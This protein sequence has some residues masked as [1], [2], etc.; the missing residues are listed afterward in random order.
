MKADSL[1]DEEKAKLFTGSDNWHTFSVREKGLRPVSMADGPHG[2]RIETKTGLG[3]NESK[4]AVCWP[5]ASALGCTFDRELIRRIAEKLSEECRSENIDLLLGPG[6]NHKRSPLCGRNFEYY[7]EDPY[8]S[9]ELGTAFVTGLQENGTGS[10]VK[11]YACN[12]REKGRLVQ[13]SIIDQRTLHEIYLRQFD[14][15]IRQAHPAAVMA[16]YNRLNGIYCCENEQ[17]LSHARDEG[18]DGI[19]IS[20][21]GAVSEPVESLKAGLNLQMPGGDHGTSKRILKALSRGKLDQAEIDENAER[22]CEFAARFEDH[23]ASA[24]DISGHLEGCLDAALESCVLLKNNGILPM[25]NQTVAVIG[26]LA[27]RPR[28]QGTGSSKVNSIVSDNLYDELIKAGYEAEYAQGYHLDDHL[29]HPKLIADAVSLAKKKELVIVAA[30]LN[31]GD[32]AEGHDRTTM[33]LPLVQN[34]LIR[35]LIR[36]NPNTVVILQAGAPVA[37]PWIEEAGAVLMAYLSGCRS[38]QALVRLLSGAVSPSGKLAETFPLKLEDT[39]CFRYFDNSILQTQYRECIYTGYRYY[40]TFDIPVLFPFGYGLSYSRFEY[41]GLELKEE[42]NRIDVSLTVTNT[43][44]YRAREI[45]EIYASMPESKIARAKKE[46][47]GFESVMLEPGESRR[48]TIP[49]LKE[50]LKYYDVNAGCRL[51]EKGT[52]LIRAAASVSDIRLQAEITLD[53]TENPYSPFAVEFM[54]WKNGTVLIDDETYVRILGNDLPEERQPLPF[55]KDTTLGELKATR[56]GRLVHH[57]VSRYIRKSPV[58]DV[59]DS[60]VFE[61]PLRLALMAWRGFTWDTVD[62]MAEILNG[63]LHRIFR[64]VRTLDHRRNRKK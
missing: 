16:A 39:P 36:V 46:L 45:V 5:T 58:K 22:M 27:V 11:H 29:I 24:F 52:Y 55:T 62:E 61:S 60:T 64:F 10:C 48:V 15:L 25:K 49:V 42:E 20:D 35:E 1:T 37:M 50:D 34:L 7:S 6:I 47:A 53:G 33:S 2:L 31:E 21:W 41:S 26:E 23:P 28:F 57:A 44:E 43:G 63:R 38:S 54:K 51:L 40:D 8:L 3:F 59:R 17:L 12:S 18:F 13:D 9:S 4:P 14:R 30:G 19:F 32:E 56:A